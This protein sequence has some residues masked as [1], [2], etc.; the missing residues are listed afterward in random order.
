MDT[1]AIEIAEPRLDWVISY[2]DSDNDVPPPIYTVALVLWDRRSLGDDWFR[3][4]HDEL[5]AAINGFDDDRF[6]PA[7]LI[8]ELEFRHI[9]VTSAMQAMR[10][11]VITK[12][13]SARVA[14]PIDF[15]QPTDT[16]RSV[17]TETNPEGDFKQAL[18]VEERGP[19]YLLTSTEM[20]GYLDRLDPDTSSLVAC[21][22]V[23]EEGH[24]EIARALVPR[25]AFEAEYRRALQRNQEQP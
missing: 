12:V 7:I 16:W 2:W 4:H 21:L 10:D 24:D 3:T 19:N 9:Y 20:I 25:R 14:D 23:F 6:A 11:E 1:T 8:H 5:A 17:Q 13:A 18:F 15:R 22:A